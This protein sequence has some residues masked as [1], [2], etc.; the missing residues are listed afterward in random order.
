MNLRI[1]PYEIKQRTM[2]SKFTIRDIRT[3]EYISSKD[4]EDFDEIIKSYNE[5]YL[6]PEDYFEINHNTI[7]GIKDIVNQK[8][9]KYLFIPDGMKTIGKEAFKSKNFRFVSLPETLTSIE[10]GVFF[11]CTNIEYIDV[12]KSV[13]YIGPYAFGYCISLEEIKLHANINSLE[14]GL[15]DGCKSLKKIEIPD[16]VEVI[17][18][19]AFE[20]CK[21]LE[22][23]KLP[24]HLKALSDCSF[25]SC[26]SLSKIDLPNTLKKLGRYC[27]A[28]SG[29][30]DVIIPDTIDEM[31][32]AV[33]MNCKCLEYVKLPNNIT[34]L[35]FALFQGC[36]KLNGI[37]LP[38]GVTTFQSNEY[39][40]P[41][42]AKSGITSLTFNY[43]LVKIN[44]A[45]ESCPY[46][47]LFKTKIHKLVIGEK[48]QVI[49]PDLF[50]TSGIQITSIDYLGTKEEFEYF[51]K[52]NLELFK[53]LTNVEEVNF[54]RI[55][56][57]ISISREEQER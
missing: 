52:N 32:E 44:K 10:A 34:T 56:M 50:E 11:A 21:S 51:K 47:L 40:F 27:F 14:H 7:V 36:T 2:Y 33:F 45:D 54:P 23:V 39:Y 29:L 12:P 24:K 53:K 57:K 8:D 38:G 4:I 49:T 26:T 18:D 55:E 31:C 13:S 35:P 20:D 16:S 43:D 15:F 28:D 1:G 3:N 17:F 22:S 41:A 46:D 19:N 9:I 25:G 48:V 30:K 42:F 6:H 37:S 5:Q